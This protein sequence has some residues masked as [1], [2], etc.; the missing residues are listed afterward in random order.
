[1]GAARTRP[2]P[3]TPTATSVGVSGVAGVAGLPAGTGAGVVR[4]SGPFVPV[5][6][7]Y[8]TVSGSCTVERTPH[9]QVGGTVA[10]VTREPARGSEGEVGRQV[11]P[12]PRGADAAGAGGL[13]PGEIPGRERDPGRRVGLHHGRRGAAGVAGA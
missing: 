9:L 4:M 1:P 12:L 10:S 13:V 6:Q 2:A 3:V 8:R 5:H 11:R 7:G